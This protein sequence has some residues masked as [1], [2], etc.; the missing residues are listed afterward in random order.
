MPGSIPESSFRLDHGFAIRP[1]LGA[2]EGPGKSIL[3]GRN[4]ALPTLD[5]LYL[6]KQAETPYRDV[7]LDTRGAHVI[8]VVGKRRSGKSF[9]LGVLAEGLAAKGWLKQGSRSDGVLILDTMNVF[10]TMPFDVEG[11]QPERSDSVRELRKWKLEPEDIDRTLFHPAGTTVPDEV[12]GKRSHFGLQIS[13]R[14]IG[15]ASS[16]RIPLRIHLAI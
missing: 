7:W 2:D 8:Y 15:V 11:T 13:R 14:R 4:S 12:K 10:L 3:V 9:T 16:R 6:G 1:E 5:A